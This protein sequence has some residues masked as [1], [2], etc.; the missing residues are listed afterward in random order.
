MAGARSPS[1]LAPFHGAGGGEPLDAAVLQDDDVSLP[2]ERMKAGR[3]IARWDLQRTCILL[4]R[5]LNSCGV[6]LVV[7]AGAWPLSLQNKSVTIM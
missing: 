7:L 6:L 4:R 2:S 1:P 3:P 5:E